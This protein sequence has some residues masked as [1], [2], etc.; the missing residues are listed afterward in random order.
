LYQIASFF[1][2]YTGT[3]TQNPIYFQN[4]A[5]RSLDRAQIRLIS[6]FIVLLFFKKR[7]PHSA[8][9]EWGL[10]GHKISSVQKLPAGDKHEAR[11]SSPEDARA[12][13]ASAE[14]RPTATNA[15]HEEHAEDAI[16]VRNRLHSN[17][18]PLASG[19]VSVLETELG[20][21][22]SG[23]EIQTRLF[24]FGTCFRKSG[25]FGKAEISIGDDDQVQKSGGSGSESDFVQNVIGP[26]AD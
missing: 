16:R 25:S 1:R 19:L 9:A 24:G 8:N 23:T 13:T 3:L 21:D 4:S 10:K 15:P 22:F 2:K 14:P 7:N 12:A 18:K 20:T 17:D 11:A 5:A 6:L 26:V